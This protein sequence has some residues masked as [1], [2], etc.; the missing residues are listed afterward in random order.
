MKMGASLSKNEFPVNGRTALITGGSQG[1]GLNVAR[2]LAEKGA[3]VIIVARDE[4]RL[5]EGIKLISVLLS[6][7]HLTTTPL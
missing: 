7:P 4:A 5:K 1:M 6:H 3:S 2:Q